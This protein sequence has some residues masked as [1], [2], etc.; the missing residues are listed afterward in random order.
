MH[1]P[2]NLFQFF[3]E[4]F[5]QFFLCRQTH[6]PTLYLHCG[7]KKLHYFFFYNNLSKLLKGK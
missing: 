3:I 4:W 5:F 1:I 2:T 6:G 7:A